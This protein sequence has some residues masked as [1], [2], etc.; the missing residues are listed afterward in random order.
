[1]STDARERIHALIPLKEVATAKTRLA[2]SLSDSLRRRLVIAMLTD[3]C[4]CLLRTRGVSGVSVL[5]CDPAAVPADCTHLDDGRLE[6][7]AAIARA[8]AA[9]ARRGAHWLLVVPGDLPLIE[10]ED[11]RAL[12]QR[13]APHSVIAAPDLRCEGT[14]ALLWQPQLP[15]APCFGE[16]SFAAHERG[17]RAAGLAFERVSL[18]RVAFDVDQREQLMRLRREA[19]GRYDFLPDGAP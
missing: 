2:E 16:L 13:R 5:T 12:I 17:A 14:N 1:L 7:N 11:V 4:R 18:P 9:L 6:L 10:P 8:A 3:V 15:F 19:G